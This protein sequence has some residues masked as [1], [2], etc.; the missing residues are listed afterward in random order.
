MFLSDFSE[1]YFSE[2]KIF[3]KKS[4][5]LAIGFFEQFSGTNRK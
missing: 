2:V 4:Q 5:S 1:D 3:S